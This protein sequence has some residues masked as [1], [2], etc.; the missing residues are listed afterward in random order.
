MLIDTVANNS[1]NSEAYTFTKLAALRK[2]SAVMLFQVILG[3]KP[4]VK[5]FYQSNYK[6]NFNPILGVKNQ[7]FIL[8]ETAV[9]LSWVNHA[10]VRLYACDS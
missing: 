8:R 9:T 6:G 5:F 2:Q 10:P 1:A 7:T 3:K 4:H